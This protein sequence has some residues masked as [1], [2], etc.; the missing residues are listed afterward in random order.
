MWQKGTKCY[1]NFVICA[2]LTFVNSLIEY[3]M[4]RYSI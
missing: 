4:K 2:N 1:D 3:F